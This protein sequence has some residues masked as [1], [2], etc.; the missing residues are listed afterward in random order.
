MKI[1][2]IFYV[3]VFSV[4]SAVR[5]CT[6]AL[7]VFCAAGLVNAQSINQSFPTPITASEISGK[8][9]ARDIGDAR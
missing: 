5:R 1:E 8:I 3:L 2:K 4:R 7:M 6:F 9:P